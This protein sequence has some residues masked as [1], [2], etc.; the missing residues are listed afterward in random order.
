[1]EGQTV[2]LNGWVRGIR[3]HG[4]VLFLDLEDESSLVQITFEK[5]NPHRESAKRLNGDSVL[6][7][8]GKIRLRPKGLQNKKIATGSIEIV[9]HEMSV[10]SLP[11]TPPFNRKDK[12]HEDLR[13]KYR[14]LEL[15][16]SKSLRDNLKLRHRVLEIIRRELSSLGFCELETPLL[17]KSTPEGARDYLVPSRNHKG[18]FYA[19]PQSPQTLKQLLMLSGFE[20]IFKLPVAFVMRICGPTANRNSANWIWK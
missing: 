20:N 18:A 12:A 19:L 13:L 15:R 16:R 14:Y 7:L 1:M 5:E 11:K 17:Y 4:P 3:D 6:S 8:K 2:T 10:L 9:P